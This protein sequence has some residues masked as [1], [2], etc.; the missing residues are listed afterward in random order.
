MYKFK[1]LEPNAY[2]RQKLLEAAELD[3]AEA[4]QTNALVLNQI[5]WREFMEIME[6]PVKINKN[7]KNAV[8]EFRKICGHKHV[9]LSWG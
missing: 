5:E 3:I 7:L 8:N 1:G 2:A 6:S 9:M 4:H